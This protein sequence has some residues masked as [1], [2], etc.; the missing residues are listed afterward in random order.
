MR[1]AALHISLEALGASSVDGCFCLYSPSASA[2]LRA[3]P[4]ATLVARANRGRLSL[5]GLYLLDM[6]GDWLMNTAHLG[7]KACIQCCIA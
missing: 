5:V 4:S 7:M 1:W 3:T 2:D 6:G